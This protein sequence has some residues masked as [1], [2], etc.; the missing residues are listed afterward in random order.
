MPGIVA[1]FTRKHR[2]QAWSLTVEY[3][4]DN[5]CIVG[6]PSECVQC[7]E[8]LHEESGGARGAPVAH[9]G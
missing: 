9:R 1:D 2:P 3:L 6:D 4:V 8:Q 5:V 7:V